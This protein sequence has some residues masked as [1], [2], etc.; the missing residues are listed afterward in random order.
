ME[1]RKEG[2]GQQRGIIDLSAPLFGNL[3]L[4]LAAYKMP[5]PALFFFDE[6]SATCIDCWGAPFMNES[7][8]K[9]LVV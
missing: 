9:N 4:K 3:G 2:R 8:F 1:R 5:D 7:R 6:K